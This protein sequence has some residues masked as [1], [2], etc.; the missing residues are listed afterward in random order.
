M[1]ALQQALSSFPSTLDETYARILDS[2]E[3]EDKRR[4]LHVLQLVC[5]GARPIRIEEAAMLW[6]VGNSTGGS[7]CADDMLFDSEDILD[8]FGGL[9]SIETLDRARNHAWSFLDQEAKKPLLILQL[10]HFSVKEYLL[11]SRAE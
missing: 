3:D 9:I 6:L 5:F 10:A 4:V 11:S 8:F 1:S 7:L 2:M